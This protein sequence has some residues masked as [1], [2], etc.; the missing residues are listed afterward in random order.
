MWLID[1]DYWIAQLHTHPIR[2]CHF[3]LLSKQSIKEGLLGKQSIKVS[4]AYNSQLI[5]G[6]FLSDIDTLT[7]H[8]N[9]D[10]S[11]KIQRRVINQSSLYLGWSAALSVSNIS[12]LDVVQGHRPRQ[13]SH[14]LSYSRGGFTWNGLPCGLLRSPQPGSGLLPSQSRVGG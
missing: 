9:L 7:G 6:H 14:S 1:I 10:H 12:L 11:Q 4:N 3:R 13:C 8:Y 2:N 5:P